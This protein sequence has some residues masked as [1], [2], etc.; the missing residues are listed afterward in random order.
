MLLLPPLRLGDVRVREVSVAWWYGGVLAP[1]VALLITIACLRSS[2]RGT[3]SASAGR[4]AAWLVPSLLLFLPVR[5]L[6]HTHEGLWTG[7][8]VVV[9]PLLAL[10]VASPPAARPASSLAPGVLRVLVVGLLFW[11]NLLLAGDVARWLGLPRLAGILMAGG[12]AILVVAVAP[13]RQR[14]RALFPLAL[15]AFGVPLALVAGRVAWLPHEAWIDVA[16]RP[17]FRFSPESPWVREGRPV[18]AQRET[19]TVRFDEEHRITALSEGPLQIL[20]SDRARSQLQ[21][22]KLKPGQSVILRPGDRLV[23]EPGRRLRFEVN[24]RVP[25]APESGMRW[26]DPPLSPTGPGLLSLLGAGVT[27][28][29]GAAALLNQGRSVRVSRLTGALAGSG[30]LLAWFWAQGWGIYTISA[31]PEMFLGGLSPEKLFELPALIL[32]DTP[33]GPAAKGLLIFGS[34]LALLASAVALKELLPGTGDERGL[35]ILMV[36]VLTLGSLWPL[37][38]WGVLVIALGLGA[39][40]LAPL[41]WVGTPTGR[42]W[43]AT[44]GVAAGLGVFLAFTALG[45]FGGTTGPWTQVLE[46]YPA[47]AAAPVGAAILRILGPPARG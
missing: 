12:G 41:A 25:G 39:S 24:K 44:I 40:T 27:I 7:L 4:I 28:L 6:A 21:E 37:D 11:T 38:P 5:L 46:S 14:W 1:L 45:R 47:L 32:A 15:L 30:C 17:A 18:Q 2:R 26:A 13:G 35:W 19:E 3:P 43:A 9:A 36:G 10:L 34:F 31:A 42:P 29:G 33:W 20:V 8:L 16:S 23:V 22:W